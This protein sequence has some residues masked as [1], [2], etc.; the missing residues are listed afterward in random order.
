MPKL[1]CQPGDI[2]RLI[3]DVIFTHR[4]ESKV[5]VK[6]DKFVR[7]VRL[8]TSYEGTLEAFPSDVSGPCWLLEEPIV[9][10]DRFSCGCIIDGEIT[11]LADEIL[12]PIR[13]SDGVDETLRIK[14]TDIV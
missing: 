1:N 5:V 2:A 14:E 8:V 7:V 3:K 9:I 4:G 11:A 13:D 6:R 12:R 10:F